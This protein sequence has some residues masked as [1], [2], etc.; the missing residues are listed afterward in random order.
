MEQQFAYDVLFLVALCKIMN[1]FIIPWHEA[2][3]AHD[4]QVQL[5]KE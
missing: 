3:C 2:M 4:H 5:S 1:K